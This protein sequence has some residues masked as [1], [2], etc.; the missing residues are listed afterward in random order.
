MKKARKQPK[1][2]IRGIH[3]RT[4]QQGP[5]PVLLREY[6]ELERQHP[7]YRQLKEIRHGA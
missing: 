7:Q 1:N 5:P 4:W 2:F 6:R 3:D